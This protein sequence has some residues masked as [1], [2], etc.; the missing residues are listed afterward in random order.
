MVV[1]EVCQTGHLVTYERVCT[2][3]CNEEEEKKKGLINGIKVG[4]KGIS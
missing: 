4:G 1:I 2:T 3:T